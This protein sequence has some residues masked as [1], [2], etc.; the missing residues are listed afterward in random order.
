MQIPEIAAPVYPRL[1][2]GLANNKTDRWDLPGT[3]KGSPPMIT[4]TWFR[5]VIASLLMITQGTL[6]VEAGSETGLLAPTGH[7]RVGVYQGSPTSMVTD[8]KPGQTHG[9]TYDLG[10]E[11]AQ[12]LSVPVEYVTFPRIADVI[13][14]IKNGQIDFTVSNAS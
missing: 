12:R 13:D 11:L 6:V 10:R 14:A 5:S 8:T 7:L 1:Q 3:M 4:A 2:P 9:L